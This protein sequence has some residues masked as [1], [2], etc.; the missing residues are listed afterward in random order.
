MTLNFLKKNL[1]LKLIALVLA[2][3]LWFFV[4]QY[5]ESPLSEVYKKLTLVDLQTLNV[6]VGTLVLDLPAQVEITVK[7]TSKTINKL[8]PEDFQ[9]YVDVKGKSLG[10][11]PLEIRVR[12]PVGVI[13][14]KIKPARVL[15]RLDSIGQKK[16]SLELKTEGILSKG[17]VM[18][19]PRFFPSEVILKG[20]ESVLSQVKKVYLMTNTSGLREDLVQRIQPAP[21][22][23]KLEVVENLEINPKFVR[24]IIPVKSSLV[25]MTLPVDPVIIDSPKT[26]FVIKKIK[27]DPP[28]ATI[29]LLEEIQLEIQLRYLRTEPISVKGVSKNLTKEVKIVKPTDVSL[30]TQDTVSVTIFIRRK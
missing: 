11:T 30:I 29:S 3:S 7:G 20:A 9:V 22:N 14:T 17:F 8:K 18:G 2:I 4:G 19:K 21:V 24:V 12:E 26:G 16:F 1:N 5:I 15:A 10:I 27:V 23:D 28:V 25:S 6:P 13:V